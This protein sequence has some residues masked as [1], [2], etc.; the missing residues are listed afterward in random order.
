MWCVILFDRHDKNAHRR[1]CVLCNREN[2]G[3]CVYIPKASNS[4][5]TAQNNSQCLNM[6]RVDIGGVLCTRGENSYY[7][8]MCVITELDGLSKRASE[9]ERRALEYLRAF[10]ACSLSKIRTPNA[11]RLIVTSQ[12]Y[13]LTLPFAKKIIVHEHTHARAIARGISDVCSAAA[14]APAT[15][16]NIDFATHESIVSD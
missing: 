8:V 3:V 4:P 9:R 5:L 12:L 1:T 10:C 15:G 6:L 13:M 16:T 14:A 7:V 11:L 2:F